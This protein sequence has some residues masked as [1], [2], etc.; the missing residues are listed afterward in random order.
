MSV[1]VLPVRVVPA[2]PMKELRPRNTRP[3]G[4]RGNSEGN[5]VNHHFDSSCII[6]DS[7]TDTTY[8]R[9]RLLGK[10]GFA[11]CY[12]LL[13]LNSN[14][15]YAGKIISKTR[16]A[17]PH[18]RQKIVREVELQKDLKH[19]HVVEFHSYFED[20]ENVYII[21]ENCS[22][23]SLVHV[24]KH[25]KTLTEPE[26]RYYLKHIV[27]GATYIHDKNIIHRDLK[28][29]NM[30]LNESME[31]KIADF[32][33]ATRVDF[34]GEKKMTVCGT[35]NYIAPEVLQ[36]KGHSFE[37][38]IW[39]VGCIMYALLV[40][41]PPFE[42]STLKETYLRIT[43]NS[44]TLPN[45]LS[46]SAKNLIRKCLSPDPA[47]RPTLDDLLADEYFTCGYMPRTLTPTAC[48]TVPKFPVY[49]KFNRPLSYAVPDT[50]NDAM[51]KL[52][53][54][55]SQIQLKG[56]S[57]T[58]IPDKEGEVC[59]DRQPLTAGREQHMVTDVSPAVKTAVKEV[60]VDVISM[61]RS[62]SPPQHRA[63]SPNPRSAVTLLDV[64]N[65]CL[66]H[67]PKG[68]DVKHTDYNNQ[69]QKKVD[70][71]PTSLPDTDVMWVTKWVD[72]SNK[73]GFGFQ[74]SNDAIGVL[75][76]DT[77]RILLAPDGRAVQYFDLTG[78]LSAFSTECIPEDLER[79][80]T[81][82]QYFA[83]YMDEHLIQ[84]GDIAHL[85]AMRSWS[86][87]LYLK[88]WFR[89]TK[90][91]VLY[92]SDGT[93]QVN[94]FD[95]HTKI[96]LSYHNNDYLVTFIDPERLAKTFSIV[97]IIQDGCRPEIIERMLFAK[98]M[99]KNLVDI[100][101]ADI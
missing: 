56:T 57:E 27:E 37:A 13:D 45:S 11:R 73:Y 25:R 75:F 88:K 99:L 70:R 32:G 42:T 96:I 33:L 59:Y 48:S 8:L 89:T 52:G 80:T 34:A 76:N 55:L 47:R 5:D 85:R 28:L 54:A 31:L 68:S 19:K 50:K 91:I 93:L 69:K 26:V 90:A 64:I 78:K 53:N 14:K 71:N 51:G 6:Y 38:D 24:L 58:I 12:E 81:L 23:K 4:G 100:E 84:G 61:D 95:D 22:R 98:T 92:L 18:Q 79:K 62:D 82:L 39:A 87:S 35:P 17:K 86:G 21:L 101:G 1:D 65:T 49:T 67:M 72:Y 77:S 74:L 63:S 3:E 2:P 40:G 97:H 43:E 83:R 44:Y 20:N 10:G 94:F 46:N 30:L 60:I 29:G 15:I 41:R 7:I 36:K 66:E 9:G 16:I